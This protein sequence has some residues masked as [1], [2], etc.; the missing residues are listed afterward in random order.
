MSEI[1]VFEIIISYIT[2]KLEAG[3]VHLYQPAPEYAI[4]I[5]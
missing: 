5:S 3:M 4:P 2:T 1:F